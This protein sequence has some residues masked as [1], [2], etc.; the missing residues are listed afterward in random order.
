MKLLITMKLADRNLKYHIYPIT[1]LKEVDKIIIVRDRKGPEMDKVE[2]YCLPSWTLKFPILAL[3]FKFLLMIYLSTRERPALIHSYLLFP[4]GFLAFLTGKLTRRKIGVSLIAGPMELYV[5]G[6][7]PVEKYAYNRPLPELSVKGKII[8]SILKRFDVIMVAGSF[9]KKFLLEKGINKNKIFTV[10]YIVIDDRCHPLPLTKIYDLVY[11]GR[12]AKVKHVEIVLYITNKLM[13][14]CGLSNLKVAIIGNG[15]CSEKLRYL[16]EKMAL[17]NNVDF[18]GFKE[19]IATY[20]NKSKLSIVTSERETGPLTVLESMMCGVP[21]IASRCSDTIIDLLKND[22]NGIV[23]RDYQDVNSFT[24]AIIKLLQ[25]PEL[26][27]K[28]STNALKTTKK[29]KVEKIAYIWE[30]VIDRIGK[31]KY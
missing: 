13:S 15:P 3:F 7:S 9:T 19:D 16:C 14:E 4:H 6:G 20:F 30:N 2:Y 8:L 11:I 22:F 21:V 12:L 28:C 17:E 18:L 31:I 5:L 26:I 10:P 25:N 29:L 23:I 24:K 1:L 27:N